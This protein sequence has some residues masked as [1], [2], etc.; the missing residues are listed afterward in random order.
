MIHGACHFGPLFRRG[1]GT[2]VSIG[3]GMAR[4][5][6]DGTGKNRVSID[7][8]MTATS[9]VTDSERAHHRTLANMKTV[10]IEVKRALAEVRW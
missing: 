8:L 1:L 2:L 4:N 5:E 7:Y 9:L 6:D 10:K 3:T